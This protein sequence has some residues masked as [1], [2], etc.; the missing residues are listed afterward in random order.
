MVSIRIYK[1]SYTKLLKLGP[2]RLNSAFDG[3][4]IQIFYTKN[5]NIFKNDC[6]DQI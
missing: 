1:N 2:L 4:L 3:K 5:D 6:L